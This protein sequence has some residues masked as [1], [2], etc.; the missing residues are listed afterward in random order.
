MRPFSRGGSAR[1]GSFRGSSRGGRGGGRG[2]FHSYESFGPP[3]E[4]IGLLF[5]LS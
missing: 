2:G 4:V 1:G 3:A 5:F